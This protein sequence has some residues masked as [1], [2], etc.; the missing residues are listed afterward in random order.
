ME[1]RCI[2]LVMENRPYHRA[3]SPGEGDLG[4]TTPARHTGTHRTARRSTPRARNFPRE[5]ANPDAVK[6]NGA[7][8]DNEKYEHMQPGET[9]ATLHGRLQE[10]IED[11]RALSTYYA[12]SYERAGRH[13]KDCLH[14]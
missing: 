8:L 14:K 3:S 4:R 1:G 10:R 9:E 7:C 12:Y 5:H 6:W 11:P 13:V 2:L